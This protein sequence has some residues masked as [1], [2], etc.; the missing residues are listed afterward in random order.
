MAVV[1]QVTAAQF[2]QMPVSYDPSGNRI[3]EELVNGEII[4]VPPPY[5][6]HDVA[7]ANINERLLLFL[8]AHPELGLKLMPETAYAVTGS[9]VLI[10]DL[11]VVRKSRITSQSKGWI[12]GAPELAIE[13]VSPV[14]RATHLK[15]KVNMYLS[16][17]SA[18]VWLV[19]IL[20]R[21]VM[22]HTSVSIRELRGEEM[23]EDATLPGFSGPV[24]AFF[25]LL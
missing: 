25:E 17:G 8:A 7:K 2:M 16:N 12:Q 21:S 3:K 22:V 6:P 1:S 9:D 19:Y 24:S 10:P 20:D 15:H 11:S 14:A 23:I 18:S 13:I 4:S 5:Q